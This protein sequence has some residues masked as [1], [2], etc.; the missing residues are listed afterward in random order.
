MNE[1]RIL[2]A[3]PY[4][5]HKRYCLNQLYDSLHRLSEFTQQAGFYVEVVVRHDP[6]E[7]GATNNV[8][9]QREFFRQLALEKDFDYL[10][11]HGADTIPSVD[12]ICK[13][14]A[15]DR[16]IVSGVYWQ[17]G[18]HKAMNAIAWLD[19]VDQ[20]MKNELLK[21]PFDNDSHIKAAGFGLDCVLIHR[22]VLQQISWFDWD[23]NDD[24]YPFCDKAKDLGFDLIIDPSIQC[25][26]WDTK[27]SYSYNRDYFVV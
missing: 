15:L 6:H 19:D 7:F 17:R 5:E 14:I 26:H 13:M 27:N 12:A 9:K 2:I 22:T 16:E 11:F 18:K 1:I 8:K 3:V 23:V 24:D 21:R 25:Q 20:E 10:F 4:H